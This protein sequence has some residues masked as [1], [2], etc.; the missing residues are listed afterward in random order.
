VLQ[1]IIEFDLGGYPAIET[2][3]HDDWLER[4]I[5]TGAELAHPH[6]EAVL[7]HYDLNRAIHDPTSGMDQECQN[8]IA[9]CLGHAVAGFAR[10]LERA[11]AEAEVDPPPVETTLQGFLAALT[12]PLRALWNHCSDLNDRMAIEAIYDEVQ[13]TGKVVKNLPEDDRE[14]RRL[15]TEEIRKT[16]LYK[17]DQVPAR[18]TGTLYGSCASERNFPNRLLTTPVLFAPDSVSAAWRDAQQQLQER[19]RAASVS[20]KAPISR[21]FDLTPPAPPAAQPPKAA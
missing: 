21:R 3:R 1:R 15:H 5:L 14:I 9:L 12:V 4:M 2:T 16:Q 8:R 13:R 20:A 19:C 6:Y 17:L 11:L 10:V 18:L 7:D